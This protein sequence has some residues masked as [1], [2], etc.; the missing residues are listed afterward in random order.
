MHF[1]TFRL[2]PLHAPPFRQCFLLR[3]DLASASPWGLAAVLRTSFTARS[4]VSRISAVSSSY[5]R[6]RSPL[7]YGLSL[8]FQLLSTPCRHDA[9]TFS[10][11]RE[12]P[13][14]RDFHP[15]VHAYSQAHERGIYPAGPCEGGRAQTIPR[16]VPPTIVPADSSPR[17]PPAPRGAPPAWR[18]LQPPRCRQGC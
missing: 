7:F 1:R 15:P 9:V 10:F 13:P 16:A 8:H 4:L 3:A 5:H 18:H 12:A 14:E 11:W 6:L 17:S 2:Q